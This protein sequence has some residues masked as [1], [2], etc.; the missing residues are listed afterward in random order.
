MTNAEFQEI[1]ETV[2]NDK[3]A[4]LEI[5]SEAYE[6]K[7]S[8]EFER[9]M[10]KMIKNF[11]KLREKAEKEMPSEN[12]KEQNP[13]QAMPGISVRSFRR[14]AAVIL[15]A[16]LLAAL[17]ACGVRWVI[18]W[19]ETQND[20]QG[21]LDVTFE[22]EKP[23]GQE[24]EFEYKRPQTPKGFEIIR[25]FEEGN[26]CEIV[27]QEIDNNVQILYSQS[28]NAEHAAISIDND[29]DSFEAIQING[30]SGYCVSEKEYCLIVWTDGISVFS[31]S[32]NAD[33]ETT[34][35]VAE[36]VS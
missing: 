35:K 30:Y 23:Q 14:A 29:D 28:G 19:N 16:A 12:E 34:Y 15:A 26:I 18:I 10:R 6:Y 8:A 11:E 25:E 1:L 27:Y 20:E 17:V 33:F 36:S 31:V 32:S 4:E 13:I 2:M 7:F 22:I 21:T 9:K 24:R 5:K 3:C